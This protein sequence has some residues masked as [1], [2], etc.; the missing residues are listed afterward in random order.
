MSST[1]PDQAAEFAARRYEYDLVAHDKQ[2]LLV[3]LTEA[4]ALLREALEAMGNDSTIPGLCLCERGSP[5]NLGCRM[6][7]AVRR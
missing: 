2:L 3:R 4:H 7:A 5:H 1:S 6:R